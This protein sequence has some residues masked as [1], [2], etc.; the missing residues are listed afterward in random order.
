MYIFL[1]QFKIFVSIK[2]Y[3]KLHNLNI[4]LELRQVEFNK[5]VVQPNFNNIYLYIRTNA[6]IGDIYLNQVII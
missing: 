1:I 6:Y 5:K 3:Y 4:Y 2:K